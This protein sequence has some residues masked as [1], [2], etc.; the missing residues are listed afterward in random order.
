MSNECE[1]ETTSWPTLLLSNLGNRHW[2][3]R[4]RAV[5]IHLNKYLMA[6][7]EVMLRLKS[8]ASVFPASRDIY[9]AVAAGNGRLVAGGTNLP[10]QAPSAR[11]VS[12]VIPGME[13]PSPL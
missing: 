12:K 8:F 3:K 10:I 6:S 9:H 7:W 4:R 13:A 2:G 5:T 11:Y 1:K